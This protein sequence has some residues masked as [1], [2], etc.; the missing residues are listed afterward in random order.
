M[1]AIK[2]TVVQP[3]EDWKSLFRPYNIGIYARVSTGTPEQLRSLGTQV[4]AFMALYR[5]K[6]RTFI[7]DVYIDV[8]SGKNCDR[9]NYRRMLDD[10]KAG[11]INLIATKSISRFGRDTLE[12]ISTI[13]ELRGLG[14]NVFF[15]SENLYS[16][17]H[18][19]ELFLTT[20]AAVAEADNQSR[21]ENIRAGFL[22]AAQAGT[23]KYYQRKCYGYTH[24]K[25]GQL[26]IDEQEAAV[27]RFIF[28]VYLDGASINQILVLLKERSIL[29]P[30][31]K[32]SWCKRTLYELISNEKYTGRIIVGKTVLAHGLV[33]KRIKNIGQS[34]QYEM[35]G[36]HPPIITE[37]MFEKAQ[38]EK[39]RRTNLEK[40]DQGL[41]RKETR[42][43]STFEHYTVS[44]KSED[45]H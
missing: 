28:D 16:L 14:V 39:A 21:S 12:A 25:D 40:T 34:E 38:K 3:K 44:L 33:S 18:N 10:A 30:T 13:R 8:V 31:G 29:S 26:V 19:D 5:D 36:S 22:S 9:P 11:R 41:K 23:S 24:D 1:S 45:D 7:Y 32:P 6:P 4:S 43:K 27:V 37:E 15:H 35:L 42:Y 20:M 2:I 17:D